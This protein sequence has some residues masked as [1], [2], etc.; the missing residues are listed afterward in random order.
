MLRTHN[1][2]DGGADYVMNITNAGFIAAC[3][4]SK[5]LAKPNA[6]RQIPLI[7]I[8]LQQRG[9]TTQVTLRTFPID[10]ATH[11]AVSYLELC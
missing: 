2:S 3:A 7:H 10:P 5:T 8:V 4:A 1:P 6:V 9:H 11:F